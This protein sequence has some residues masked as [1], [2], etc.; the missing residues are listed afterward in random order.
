VLFDLI[1]C[2]KLFDLIR[3]YLILFDVI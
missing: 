1:W 2:F 3:S